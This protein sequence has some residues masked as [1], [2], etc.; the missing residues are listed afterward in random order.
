[1]SLHRYNFNG[2]ELAP[3]LRLRPDLQK[4]QVGLEYCD[5]FELTK[6][7]ALARRPGWELLGYLGKMNGSMWDGVRVLP[8]AASATAQYAVVLLTHSGRGADMVVMDADTG[9]IE[10]NTSG[11]S[12]AP[13]P[14]TADELRAVSYIQV[15]DVMYIAHGSHHPKIL[16]RKNGTWTLSDASILQG[17]YREWDVD[18]PE[19]TIA[20]NGSPSGST[21]PVT[22]T[23]GSALFSEE[24]EGRT[25]RVEEELG[26][27]YTYRGTSDPQPKDTVLIGPLFPSGE[28]A[29][30]VK[31]NFDGSVF[32]Q[33]WDPV[34]EEWETIKTFSHAK[35]TV[36]DLTYT[37]F[38]SRPESQ[39]RVMTGPENL[40]LQASDFVV[41]ITCKG[42]SYR[43][44][45]L[46]TY[47]S[48]T[49][50]DGTIDFC[51][52]TNS[53]QAFTA[54]RWSRHAWSETDGF[55]N[56]VT[57]FEERLCF[58]GSESLPQQ[59]WLSRTNEW[60][61]FMYGE[62]PASPITLTLAADQRNQVVA[63]QPMRADLMILTD[64]ATFT[65]ST[66][67]SN[68]GLTVNNFR[69]RRQSNYGSSCISPV[70]SGERLYYALPNRKE[71]RAMVE[72]DVEFYQDLDTSVLG[73]HLLEG[74]IRNIVG[75]D[76]R[77][78][79]LMDDATLA[80]YLHDGQQ[81][82]DGWA[83]YSLNTIDGDEVTIQSICALPPTDDTQKLA[84]VVLRG[85]ELYA[86][87]YTDRGMYYDD[88]F[89]EY[90]FSL[91][92]EDAFRNLLIQNYFQRWGYP[93]YA[94]PSYYASLRHVEDDSLLS[95]GTDFD[96]LTGLLVA[97]PTAASQWRDVATGTSSPLE[98]SIYVHR[99]FASNG[100]PM[101][102][103]TS[104][105]L[106]VLEGKTAG[107]LAVADL[108][109]LDGDGNWITESPLHSGDW[110]NTFLIDVNE[111]SPGTAL[112]VWADGS[113]QLPSSNVLAMGDFWLVLPSTGSSWNVRVNDDA[114]YSSLDGD[115]HD[116][117]SAPCPL[118]KMY[119]SEARYSQ[120][121]LS[122][123]SPNTSYRSVMVT[124]DISGQDGQLGK[125]GRINKLRLYV[126]KNG[127]TTGQ[128]GGGTV[129][130]NDQPFTGGDPGNWSGAVSQTF[131][132]GTGEV[133][134][135]INS[136]NRDRMYVMVVSD[137]A[138]P[139]TVAAIGIDMARSEQ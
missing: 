110:L 130:I 106:L 9:I 67:S 2:G 139:L 117:M 25:I 24:W 80:Y 118:Q 33:E 84:G 36:L 135:V 10:H 90:D 34:T 22:V 104:G 21:A 138:Y 91:N 16:K 15:N 27:K 87:F 59:I 41:S 89:T 8:F 50:M 94:S 81:E 62:D 77:L 124:T 65:L 40:D 85:D 119:V 129:Y 114:V 112:E 43:Y 86:G 126:T 35:G 26:K 51:D 63:L 95:V 78:Y 5:N 64:C 23:A 131:A 128:I 127:D 39:V 123:I 31:S 122:E 46:E 30:E 68:D 73:Y 113:S 99:I 72:M 101:D 20:A 57:I 115:F 32:L 58:G 136:G 93:G 18:D 69:V 66:R 107:H 28:I 103:T 120:G 56:A 11:D 109:Y 4:Y 55:P 105:T 88:N 75:A 92:D 121:A 102:A 1:M 29:V 53:P 108:Q 100:A 82:I 12:N 54:K 79:C 61:N 19:L 71:I 3:E 44:V 48:A 98:S 76:D 45:T 37:T 125:R 111:W 14:Y 96:S 83:R 97:M 13:L 133:E 134:I 52:A 74:G 70:W 137:A 42:S 49:E 7:G 60:D 132:A 17:P 47:V 38:V 6:Y 116:L